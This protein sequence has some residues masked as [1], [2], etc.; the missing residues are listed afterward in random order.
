MKSEPELEKL[1]K[2][3]SNYDTIIIGTPVRAYTYA[4]AIR[5]FLKMIKLQD[6]KIALFCTHEWGKGKTLENMKENLVNNKI[7]SNIDFVN[8]K[9]NK[10]ANMEKAKQRANEVSSAI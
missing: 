3:P 2:D 9:K 5:T 4:P 10:I 7:I 8:V 1:H 6:K